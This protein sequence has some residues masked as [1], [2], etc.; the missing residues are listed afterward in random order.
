MNDVVSQVKA[1]CTEKSKNSFLMAVVDAE[2]ILIDIN[3]GDVKYI[4]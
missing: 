2:L 3:N 1:P 4:L